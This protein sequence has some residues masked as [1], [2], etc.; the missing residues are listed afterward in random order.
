MPCQDHYEDQSQSNE[1]IIVIDKNKKIIER[2]NEVTAYLCSTLRIL[3][4]L[5]D[6]STYKLVLD[7]NRFLLEWWENHLYLDQERELIEKS[8][9]INEK[10]LKDLKK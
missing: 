2:L 7:S 5:E 9:E 3:S 4:S 10:I 1:K 6:K 8:R